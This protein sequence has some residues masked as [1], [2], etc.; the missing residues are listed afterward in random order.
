MLGRKPQPAASEFSPSCNRPLPDR[1]HEVCVQVVSPSFGWSSLPSVLVVWSPVVTHQVHRSTLRR[2]MCLV[3]NIFTFLTLPLM[4][5]TFVL[6]L[7]KMLVP[8]ALCDVEHTYFNSGLC[9]SNFALCLFGQ[10]PGLCT[11]SHSRQHTL[12]IG[13]HGAR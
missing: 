1:V 7:T 11:M 8:L 5:M 13:E 12:V 6:F 10:C 4:S 3:Q 2:L 9:G